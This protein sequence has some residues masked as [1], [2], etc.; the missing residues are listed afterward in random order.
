MQHDFLRRLRLS[1]VQDTEQ[2]KQA[3]HGPTIK[4]IDGWTG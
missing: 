3:Q 2:Y 1:F 4:K